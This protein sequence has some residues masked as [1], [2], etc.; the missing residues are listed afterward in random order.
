MRLLV[1][2]LALGCLL[3]AVYWGFFAPRIY[4]HH[5]ADV[6]TLLEERLV[7]NASADPESRLTLDL[8]REQQRQRNI[9]SPALLL[10]AVGLVIFG[11]KLPARQSRSR[12]DEEARLAS[13]VVQPGGPNEDRL[14]EA[15][16]LLGVAHR[17]PSEVI[18]AAYRAQLDA[19]GPPNAPGRNAEQTR[20]AEEHLRRLGWAK[21]LL[22]QRR[23]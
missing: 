21:D 20:L 9:F 15:A 3:L 2:L 5:S 6:R 11:V 13:F 8:L 17:A 18:H 19:L 1:F 22:L 14:N 23:R 16:N 4:Q 10:I 7:I 12:T